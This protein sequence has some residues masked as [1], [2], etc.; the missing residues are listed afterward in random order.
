MIGENAKK[1]SELPQDGLAGAYGHQVPLNE[2]GA[3][4]AIADH[5]A[6]G[7]LRLQSKLPVPLLTSGEAS[8]SISHLSLRR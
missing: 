7:Y 1:F 4:R 5:V 6:G 3:D 2:Q 8:L